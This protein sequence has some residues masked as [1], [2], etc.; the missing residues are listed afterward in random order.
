MLHKI[1]IIL[2]TLSYHSVWAGDV[3]RRLFLKGAGCQLFFMTSSLS[4]EE[5]T[6]DELKLTDTRRLSPLVRSQ[7]RFT[8]GIEVLGLSLQQ[9]LFKSGLHFSDGV[10]A[11]KWREKLGWRIW[12]KIQEGSLNV[13][14]LASF[15]LRIPLSIGLGN[16]K[17]YNLSPEFTV[18]VGGYTQDEERGTERRIL[19][20]WLKVVDEDRPYIDFFVQDQPWQSPESVVFT[21]QD[22]ESSDGSFAEELS[23]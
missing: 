14:S 10:A 2:T 1:L 23:P 22:Q 7:D 18:E 12:E 15:D 4:A 8:I 21:K 17:Y 6:V 11:K 16:D 9:A 19:S 20:V 3:P 5:S 13:A